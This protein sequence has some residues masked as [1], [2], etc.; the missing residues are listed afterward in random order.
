MLV[1]ENGIVVI[2]PT[3]EVLD[4]VTIEDL[5]ESDM[6]LLVDSDYPGM[7]EIVAAQNSHEKKKI[8]R[9][10]A[11]RVLESLVARTADSARGA[12]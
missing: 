3:N 5:D 9:D 2:R 11:K 8:A 7:R 12:G 10:T 6:Q 4:H 1:D